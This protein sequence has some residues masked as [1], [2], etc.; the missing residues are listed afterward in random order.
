MLS[1]A[2]KSLCSQSLDSS[3][4]E[5]LVV[6]NG[7]TDGTPVKVRREF[8]GLSNLKWIEEPVPGLSR[9]RNRAIAE[10]R[11]PL[12]AFMDDDATASEKWLQKIVEGFGSS[13]DSVWAAGGK[14]EP[15]FEIERPSWLSQEI[16]PFCAVVD[17][18]PHKKILGPAEWIIGT[19]MA[20]RKKNLN[21]VGGFDERFKLYNDETFLFKKIRHAGGRILYDPEIL[22]RHHFMEKLSKKWFR[23]R[24]FRQGIADAVMELSAGKI[25]WRARLREMVSAG[26]ILFSKSASFE[27]ELNR[28]MK[29]GYA[30][31]ILGVRA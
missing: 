28:L 10:S 24:Y 3:S 30:A 22:V 4:Y 8:M 13:D 31:G 27:A 19:N 26:R 11:A 18:G 23:D 7:S 29:L 16:L 2:I 12:L 6:D 1:R 20:F 25:S 9:A 21:E 17:W 15:V 5:I 14:V